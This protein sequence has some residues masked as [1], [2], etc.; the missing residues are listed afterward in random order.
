MLRTV[1]RWAHQACGVVRPLSTR[2]SRIVGPRTSGVAGVRRK[3]VH[4]SAGSGQRWVVVR[5]LPAGQQQ[6]AGSW[7][8][9]AGWLR[10]DFGAST[11]DQSRP[12]ARR[13]L[14]LGEIAE[15]PL[16]RRIAMK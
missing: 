13:A 16:R 9:A 5:R 14:K 4:R 11:V 6:L 3:V 7:A 12:A 1:G 15:I 8:T 10:D 2:S